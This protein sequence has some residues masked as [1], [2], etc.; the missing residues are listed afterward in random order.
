MAKSSKKQIR[1]HH[2]RKNLNTK[3]K[4]KNII[5]CFL[6]MLNT[7]KVY[8]WKTTSYSTHKATDHLYDD[9]NKKIDEFV[10]VMIG[11]PDIGQMRNSMLN[12]TANDVKITNFNNNNELKKEIEIY[13]NFLI[14]LSNEP[15]FN[16]DSTN[17]DLLAIRD[18]ILALLNQFLYLLTLY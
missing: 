11:K 4:Y 2:T 1:R 10:E 6:S 9:L 3:N 14:S 7:V 8:H 12:M 13:K 18:E 16:R 5:S 15:G 17:A